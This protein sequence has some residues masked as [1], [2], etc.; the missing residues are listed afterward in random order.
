MS[1][2][3]LPSLLWAWYI[4]YLWNYEPG[5]WVHASASTFRFFAAFI[6]VP[7]TLLVMF[8][9]LSLPLPLFA[10]IRNRLISSSPPFPHPRVLLRYV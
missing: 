6:I 1:P 4:E 8:V 5:S 2:S 7:L 3:Q 10:S 9:S